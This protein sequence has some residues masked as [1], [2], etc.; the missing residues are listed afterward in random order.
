MR[1]VVVRGTERTI[2]EVDPQAGTITIGPRSYPFR[3]VEDRP[4]KVE[5][6]IAGE[7]VVV[8]GWPPGVASPPEPVSV[9]GECWRAAVEP[10]AESNADPIPG[11]S[12]AVA[13][14]PSRAPASSAAPEGEPILPPM[15]GRILEVRVASGDHVE[16]GAILLVLEAMKMRNEIVAPRAGRVSSVKVAPGSNV[17]AREPMLYLVGD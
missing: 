2:V 9:N 12:P 16:A 1:V 15:P 3:I 10:V 5:L 6:E 13:P 8:E 7:K 17:R 14:T 4:L 11:A